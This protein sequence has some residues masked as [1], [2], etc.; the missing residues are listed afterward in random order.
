MFQLCSVWRYIQ[1]E[2]PIIIRRLDIV[3]SIQK[4]STRHEAKTSLWYVL[5]KLVDLMSDGWPKMVFVL[6]CCETDTV[7]GGGGWRL[8]TLMVQPEQVSRV[9]SSSNRDQNLE[10]GHALLLELWTTCV[11]L[12]TLVIC[13]LSITVCTEIFTLYY[14]PIMS[15]IAYG[16]LHWR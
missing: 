14:V 13:V 9:W 11:Y 5:I 4:N 10:G 1:L 2:L 16:M 3:Y 12:H 15:T 8:Q 6:I 7:M